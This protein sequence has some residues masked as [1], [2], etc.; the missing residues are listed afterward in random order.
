MEVFPEVRAIIDLSIFKDKENEALSIIK[1]SKVCGKCQGGLKSYEV[2]DSFEKI[3]KIHTELTKLKIGLSG[4]GISKSSG[5]E[6][7]ASSEEESSVSYEGKSSMSSG[8]EFSGSSRKES[9]KA[10]GAKSTKCSHTESVR[11][12]MEFGKPATKSLGAGSARLSET[13][14]PVSHA[15][16]NSCDHDLITVDRTIMSYIE[17]THND[18][19]QKIER[20]FDVIRETIHSEQWS[21]V[22]FIQNKKNIPSY[23]AKEKFIDF[24]QRIVTN[25]CM[26]TITPNLR[27]RGLTIKNVEAFLQKNFPKVWVISKDTELTLFGSTDDVKKVEVALDSSKRECIDIAFKTKSA[28]PVCGEVYG[29]LKGNQPEGGRMTHRIMQMHL[30]GYEKYDTIE[31]HYQIPDGFQGKEHPQPGQRYNGTARTAY[32]PNSPE[33]KKV[34]RLLQRAFNQKLIFTVGTSSTT[35]RSNVVTW[36][37]IHHKTSVFGGPS[38]FGYPDPTYL[39]RVQDE[40]KAKGIF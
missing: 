18:E 34:L 37:D 8:T 33:G 25:L 9:V 7:R 24:Y 32:L 10:S 29:E 38:A 22:Q 13:E 4:T 19:L 11:S 35:G 6:P 30:P 3:D 27:G 17:N 39:A 12:G 20:D 2:I 21:T 31:I 1:L 28:C 15:S 26:S 36:N 23:A 14:T 16:L 40:L 5:A